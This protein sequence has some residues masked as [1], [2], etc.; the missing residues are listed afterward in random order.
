MRKQKQ[1]TKKGFTLI[2]L[3]VVIG[4]ITIMTSVLF[5]MMSNDKDRRLVRTAAEGFVASVRDAQNIALTGQSI[6]GK[7]PCNVTVSASSNGFGYSAEV[8]NPN[9]SSVSGQP[10]SCT[11]GTETEMI[12]SDSTG[13]V[14]ITSSSGSLRPI[15]INAPFGSIASSAFSSG[16]A[17]SDY[18]FSLSGHD[19]RVCLY[20]SGRVEAAGFSGSCN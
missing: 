1:Q 6:N 19:Y 10:R 8:Y 11:N 4:I 15:S 5:V 17:W 13:R 3:L 18:V 9:G 7:R 2:E 12:S 14:T 16:N 20:R